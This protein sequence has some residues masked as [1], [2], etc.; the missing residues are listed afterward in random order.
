MPKKQSQFQWAERPSFCPA[1]RDSTKMTWCTQSN[2]Q[3]TAF[4]IRARDLL[5]QKE[6]ECMV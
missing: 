4:S 5:A 2:L 6:G 1:P 3:I